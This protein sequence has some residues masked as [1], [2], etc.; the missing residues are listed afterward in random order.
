MITLL[1]RSAVLAGA[2]VALLLSTAAAV[3]V[4]AAD[5]TAAQVLRALAWHAYLPVTPL[6]PLTDSIVWDLRTPRVL[7][8]GLVGAGLAVC[9]AVLQ[10]LTRNALADPYLLGISAGASTGAVSVLV[11]GFAT[12]AAALSVGA[13]AGSAAAFALALALAGRRWTEPSRILL[14]GVAAGQLFSAATS[15]IVVSDATA[16]NTRS[17]TF[18]LLGSLTAA[19]WTSV[20]LCAAAGAA[21]LVCC[22]AA[23]PALDAFSFGTDVAQSLGFS[24][25]RVRALLFTATAVLAAALVAAS[26][27]IGFVG[28]T[29]PHAARALAGARHRVLLPACA[30]LGAIFLIWADTAA[31]T[32]FAPQEVPVGVVTALIGVPAF[33]VLLRRRGARE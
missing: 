6:D 19:S 33:A 18:W 23:A 17:I 10:A 30:L 2:L 25:T 15:L 20:A 21:V 27:A 16:Q 9:G 7:L 1:G 8:A 22:W 13:F 11:F 28:L 4:G 26:G 32:V 3:A 14:A 29:V 12:G 5:L 31:R 24:P